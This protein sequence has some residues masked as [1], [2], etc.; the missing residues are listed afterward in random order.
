MG[1]FWLGT[2]PALLAA[3]VGIQRLSG[4]LRAR[5]PAL[6]AVAVIVIGALTVSGRLASG[7]RFSSTT[8]NV[9]HA[10]GS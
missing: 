2:V 5:L 1:V 9:T 8:S 7:V 10:H 4:P 3:A 6:T